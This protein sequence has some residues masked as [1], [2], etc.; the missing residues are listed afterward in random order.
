MSEHFS[1]IQKGVKTRP[2][3]IQKLIITQTTWEKHIKK[4]T[5]TSYNTNNMGITQRKIQTEIIT[6]TTWDW[7]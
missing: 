3:K 2:R 7:E 4:N 6:Q 1:E 5:N